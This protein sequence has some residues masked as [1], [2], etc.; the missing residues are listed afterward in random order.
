MKTVAALIGAFAF[1]TSFA[2]AKPTNDIGTDYVFRALNPVAISQADECDEA[3][4][5]LGQSIADTPGAITRSDLYGVHS[6]K[7]SGVF[8]KSPKK[9]VGES[10][11][12]LLGEPFF[13]FEFGE[14][15]LNY[16]IAVYLSFNG[17]SVVTR[18]TLTFRT[19]PPGFG[20]AFPADGTY[21]MI[22]QGDIFQFRDGIPVRLG[23]Y[24][25]NILGSPSPVEGY[26]AGSIMTLRLYRPLS[27]D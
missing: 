8:S 15:R 23:T 11:G 6:K 18:G 13:T 27:A 7:A 1:G 14:L 24:T 10:V 5:I 4:S 22:T 17:E 2:L 9:K 19:S 26:S 16:G 21:L 25:S 20:P 12:C 3:A